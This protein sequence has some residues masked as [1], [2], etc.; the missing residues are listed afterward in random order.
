VDTGERLLFLDLNPAGQWLFLPAT[1]VDAATAALAG[2]LGGRRRGN[3][4][5]TPR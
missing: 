2:W 3:S 5:T 4:K 1:I